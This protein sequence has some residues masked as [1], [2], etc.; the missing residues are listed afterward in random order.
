MTYVWAFLVL[1][2]MAAIALM[3]LIGVPFTRKVVGLGGVTPTGGAAVVAG[4]IP[5]KG[6]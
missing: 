5:G 4:V 1:L 2:A 6:A 3:V